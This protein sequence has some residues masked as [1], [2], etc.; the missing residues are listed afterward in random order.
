MSPLSNDNDPNEI[1]QLLTQVMK[2]LAGTWEETGF[3]RIEIQSERVRCDR[4]A[5]TVLGS[6][7]YRY[8]ISDEDVRRWV[9]SRGKSVSHM[10]RF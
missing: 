3:G 9:E 5:V 1:D 6:T 4:I 2:I 8:V 7:H 10:T